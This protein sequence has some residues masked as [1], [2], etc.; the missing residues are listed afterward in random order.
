MAEALSVVAL[1]VGE[2]RLVTFEVA[3]SMAEAPCVVSGAT[4]ART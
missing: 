4:E 3:L 1:S 2:A